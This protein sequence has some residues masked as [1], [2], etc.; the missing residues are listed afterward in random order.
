MK[1]SSVGDKHFVVF[2][3]HPEDTSPEPVREF[4][5]HRW[6]K[7][8]KYARRL[9]ELGYTHVSVKEYTVSQQITFK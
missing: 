4:D 5:Y 6:Q 7:S 1:S 2:A 9:L 8:I 3:Q